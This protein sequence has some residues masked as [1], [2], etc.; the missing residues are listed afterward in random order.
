MSL[1]DSKQSCGGYLDM[2]ASGKLVDEF[3]VKI[4]ISGDRIPWQ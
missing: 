2:L 1:T 4:C 3:L